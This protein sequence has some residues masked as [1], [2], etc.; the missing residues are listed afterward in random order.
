VKGKTFALWGLAFKPR[1]D[2]LREA[3]SKTIIE[4]LLAKGAKIKAFDPKATMV[5]RQIFGNQIAYSETAY[6]A[7]EEADALLLVTEWNE[8]RRPDFDKMKKLMKRAVIFDGRN[9]Y[10]IERMGRRGFEYYCVGRPGVDAVEV[11]ET[12]AQQRERTGV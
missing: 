8:F 6:E 11:D 5:A 1:T 9:Q 4:A 12:E 10:E 7:L 3:P 2:D